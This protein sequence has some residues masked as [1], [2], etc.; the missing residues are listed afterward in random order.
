MKIYIKRNNI[1]RQFQLFVLIVLAGYIS[2]QTEELV[3]DNPEE[4]E[5]EVVYEVFEMKIH[6]ANDAPVISKEPADYLG[7]S[8]TIDGKGIED[9]YKGAA[10]IR[11]RG[12]STWLWYDKKPYRIKLEEK[13]E[14]LGLKKNSDWVLLANYRDPTNLMNTF[15]FEVAKW[16]G[17]PYTNNSRYVELSLNGNYVGLYQLTEQVETGSNRINIDEIEGVLLSLDKD[18][19]PE[20]SPSEGNNFWS[21]VFKMPVCIKHPNQPTL[22]QISTVQ[23]DFAKLEKAIDESNYDSVAALLDIASL[24]D[25]L[26]LQELVYNVEV[27]APRSVFI[28]KDKGGKYVMGPVWDFDAGFDFD[29]GSMYTGH[30][31]FRAQELLLGTDPANHKNGYRVPEFFTQ[32]FRNKQFVLEYKERWNEIKDDIFVVAWRSMEN[33]SLALQEAME[34]DFK[35]WP[36]D[37][38]YNTEIE[39]MEEWLENRVSHL[40]TIINNYP[41][42]SILA[43]H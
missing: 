24:I 41:E 39:R 33:Y 15:G 20:L 11:G 29:W 14:I 4:K 40:T 3:Q 23:K 2:C 6:V 37:K 38:N 9:D 7:C 25:F 30:N 19:G 21:S 26:I 32:L 5:I 1:I 42:G 8:V 18:D 16:L 27:D 28:H 17:L 43:N 22:I 10:R 31:Y 35:R 34:R 12:N 13:A 36:I